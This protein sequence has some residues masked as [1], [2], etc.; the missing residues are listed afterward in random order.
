MRLC[1]YFT[2]T[3]LSSQEEFCTFCAPVFL[4][5]NFKLHISDKTCKLYSASETK[6]RGWFRMHRTVGE[7][8]KDRRKQLG[9]SPDRI[10][11][12]LGRDRSTYFRYEGNE[13]KSLPSKV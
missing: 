4:F 9:L 2:Y 1:H 3:L 6:N 5:S 7:R 13:I 11:A 8:I 12:Y 10:A